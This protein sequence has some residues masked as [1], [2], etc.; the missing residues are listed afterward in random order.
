[1]VS[2]KPQTAVEPATVRALAASQ[3]LLPRE[4]CLHMEENGRVSPGRFCHSIQRCCNPGEAFPKLGGLQ[5]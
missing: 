1:M 3:I 5:I 2:L 4:A